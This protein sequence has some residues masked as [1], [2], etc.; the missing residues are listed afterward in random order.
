[1]FRNNYRTI[2]CIYTFP[3]C[4]KNIAIIKKSVGWVDVDIGSSYPGEHTSP[5]GYRLFH[6][7]DVVAVLFMC[8]IPK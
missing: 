3:N 8:V 6:N 4:F 1:M 2:K 5:Y 7:V